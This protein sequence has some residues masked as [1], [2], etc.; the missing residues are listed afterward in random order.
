MKMNL[1]QKLLRLEERKRFSGKRSVV[2]KRRKKA[3]IPEGYYIDIIT[4]IPSRKPV[5]EKD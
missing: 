1:F 4:T 3:L 2:S 5:I